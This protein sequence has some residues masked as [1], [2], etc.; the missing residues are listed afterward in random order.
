MLFILLRILTH[1]LGSL[2]RP[3]LTGGTFV[4][5]Y[6]LARFFI[7]FFRQPDEQ[8]GFVIGFMT[9]GMILSL[10]MILVGVTAIIWSLR[11]RKET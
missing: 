5:G 6:G 3:G 4:A 11:D 1:S 7:E 8:L 2:H 9:M 10:P